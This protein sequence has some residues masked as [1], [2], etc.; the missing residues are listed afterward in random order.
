MFAEFKRAPL[1]EK[2]CPQQSHYYSMRSL[3][4]ALCPVCLKRMVALA[5]PLC[6][7][8]R[9]RRMSALGEGYACGLSI[10]LT[11]FM[12]TPLCKELLK[13]PLGLPR[14][15]LNHWGRGQAGLFSMVKTSGGGHEGETPQGAA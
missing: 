5:P 15:G 14:W 12:C 8:A 10:P 4:E 3:V 6:V 2:H 13:K 11:A 1:L 9:F 7:S